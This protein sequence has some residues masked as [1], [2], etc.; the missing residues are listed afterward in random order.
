MRFRCYRCSNPPQYYEFS[1]K[2]ACPKCG[3]PVG[4]APAVV[5]LNDVHFVV[6]D[7][8][9]PIQGSFGRQYIACDPRREGLSLHPGDGYSATDDP[10]AATCPSCRG[11]QQYKDVAKLFPEIE[12]A[13]RQARETAE[14]IAEIEKQQAKTGGITAGK[15]G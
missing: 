13:E 6:L 2:P 8:R 14:L 9:G 10:R 1:D 5:E 4:R 15:K 3:T 7:K 11:T 12:A